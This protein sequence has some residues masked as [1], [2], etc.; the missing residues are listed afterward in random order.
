MTVLPTLQIHPKSLW[1]N[2]SQY[3]GAFCYATKG[4]SMKQYIEYKGEKCEVVEIVNKSARIATSKGDKIILVPKDFEAGQATKATPVKEQESDAPNFEKMT[5]AEL[6]EY[7]D[8]NGIAVGVKMKKAEI[9]D[10]IVKA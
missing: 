10:A 8:N 7:A 2:A 5:K 3:G 6:I 4:H 9:I 1:Q